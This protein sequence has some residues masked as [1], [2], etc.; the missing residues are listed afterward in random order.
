MKRLEQL[1][2][3]KC[4]KGLSAIDIFS[5]GG[6]FACGDCVREYYKNSDQNIELE[7][8]ERHAFARRILGKRRFFELEHGT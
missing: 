3:C 5:F 6:A 2:C 8:E 1:K 7:L 4:L